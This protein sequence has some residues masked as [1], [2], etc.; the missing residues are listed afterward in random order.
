MT[1][2]RLARMVASGFDEMG[3]RMDTLA[4]KAELAA[5]DRRVGKVEFRVDEIHDI[6]K[7]FEEQDILNLQRRVHILEKAVKALANQLSK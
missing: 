1:L 6:L 2:D 7:R 4:T 3:K 5:V